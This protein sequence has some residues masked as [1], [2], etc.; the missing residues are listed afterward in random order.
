MRLMSNHHMG[1]LVLI[2]TVPLRLSNPRHLQIH[3]RSP[4]LIP[5]KQIP[6]ILRCSEEVEEEELEREVE[7]GAAVGDSTEVEAEFRWVY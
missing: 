5:G 1:I 7:V 2:S 3:P 4:S 6:T